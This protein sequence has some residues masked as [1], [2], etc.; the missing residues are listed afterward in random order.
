VQQLAAHARSTWPGAIR[1]PSRLTL[2]LSLLVLPCGACSDDETSVLAP[3]QPI[4]GDG[5][6]EAPLYAMSS[7]VFGTDGNATTTT[8][9]NLLDSLEPQTVDFDAAREFP[10]TSDLWVDGGR[11]FVADGESL[12]VTKYALEGDA[13]VE[14]ESVSF[15]GYG[16]ASL[17]FWLNKFIS[18]TKAYLF[19]DASE[20]IVW[21]PEA[22]EITGTIPLPALDAPDGFQLFNGYSDR[23][24]V[25]RDGRL[26]QSF[27]FTDQSFFE[28]TP[29]SLIAVFDVE[30]DTLLDVLDVPCPGLDHA[31][32]D[33]RG[34]IYFSGWVYAAGGAVA[35]DQPPTCVVRVPASGAEP[36][37][38]FKFAD[39]TGGREGGVM[40]YIGNGRALIS[41]LHD[42]RVTLTPTTDPSEVAFA[43]NW[44][45]WTYDIASGSASPIDTIDWNA[46]AQYSFDIDR[47]TLMLVALADYSATDVYDLGDGTNPSSLIDTPGWSVRLFKV[48]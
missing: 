1:A 4:P 5:E 2:L 35:L 12:T 38:A 39:V 24:A 16:L 48:R 25:V 21:N 32:V 46:G 10:G 44:R 26:Y 14:R 37:V 20:A 11:I 9:I 40:R 33:D 7:L 45:F 43:A 19:N 47:R 3:L 23:A 22:M 27:Y 31:T 41:V 8:Y 28:F 30:T 13:L 15:A 29:N 36:N 6:P 34:D 18:P 17:G 42:E